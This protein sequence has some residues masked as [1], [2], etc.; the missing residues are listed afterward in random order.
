MIKIAIGWLLL[1]LACAYLWHKFIQGTKGPPEPKEDDPATLALVNF[2]AKEKEN[3]SR[4]PVAATR[5]SVARVEG[6]SRYPY[7]SKNPTPWLH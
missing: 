2:F 4:I 3:E 5:P 1:S 7:G 6:A